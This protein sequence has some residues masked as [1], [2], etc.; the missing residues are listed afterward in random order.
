MAVKIKIWRETGPRL[1]PATA[2][3]AE[4]IVEELIAATNQTRGS[5]LAV[6]A[7][8]FAPQALPCCK[9]YAKF[10]LGANMTCFGLPV[11]FL[12][13]SSTGPNSITAA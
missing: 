11:S 7:G 2:M 3:E 1:A 8:R 6:L 5:V 12:A 13:S 9:T 4:E 10:Y